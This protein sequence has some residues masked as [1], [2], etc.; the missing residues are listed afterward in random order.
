MKA[1]NSFEKHGCEKK[2]KEM[3]QQLEMVNGIFFLPPSLL[4]F[5]LLLIF[6]PSIFSF[7]FVSV[8]QKC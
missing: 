1:D 4:S 8:R 5:F 3:E 2:E 7:L 6:L